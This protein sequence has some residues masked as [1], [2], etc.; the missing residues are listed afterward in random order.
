MPVARE[1]YFRPNFL[2]VENDTKSEF[3]WSLAMS[4]LKECM[5]GHESCNSR[6]DT[7][8]AWKPSRILVINEDQ[9]SDTPYLQLQGLE[10]I[11]SEKVYTTLSHCWGKLEMAVLTT[12]NKEA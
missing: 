10:D 8:R 11:P 9:H 7:W 6:A 2:A 5:E 3:A 4:W 1:V 12:K